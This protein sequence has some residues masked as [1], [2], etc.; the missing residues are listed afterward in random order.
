VIDALTPGPVA[1][2][3]EG[4][5][6]M[7]SRPCSFRQRDVTAAIKAVRVAGCSVA[8]VEVDP[9][10]G[11]IVVLARCSVEETAELAPLDAW[12]ASRGPR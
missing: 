5:T 9:V 12:R 4:L 11:K 10:T 3:A 1:N 7:G 8:R 2:A 6:D